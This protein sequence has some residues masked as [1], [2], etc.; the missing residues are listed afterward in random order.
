MINTALDVITI[1]EDEV[2]STL[3]LEDDEKSSV[4]QGLMANL[5]ATCNDYFTPG[6]FVEKDGSTL[7]D[8]RRAFED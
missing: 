7:Q 4:F 6:I 3:W 8:D 1:I 5:W 2:G